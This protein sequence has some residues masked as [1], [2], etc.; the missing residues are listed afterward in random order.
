MHAVHKKCI[1]FFTGFQGNSAAVTGIQIII[2]GSYAVW[3]KLFVMKLHIFMGDC[4]EMIRNI[5]LIPLECC[6]KFQVS[7]NKHVSDKHI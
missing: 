3:D 1:I 6:I 5:F 4:C 2:T 7:L